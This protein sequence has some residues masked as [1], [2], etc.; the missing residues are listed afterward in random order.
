MLKNL[1][2]QFEKFFFP[3]DILS[4]V[5]IEEKRKR[6]FGF[7]AAF[8]AIPLLLGY[9]MT[10][11]FLGGE[12]KQIWPDLLAAGLLIAVVLILRKTQN[13]KIIYRIAMTGISGLFFYN[14][15][16]GL[17]KGGDILWLYTYPLIV[18]FLFGIVEGLFWIIAM[19][20]PVSVIVLFP[21]LTN[22]F[23]FPDVFKTRFIFSIIIVIFM[24]WLFESL[25]SHFFKQLTEQK[26]K[27]EAALEDVKTLSG[28]LPICSNCKKIR[29]DEGYW[30]QIEG[31]IQK[32]S[33]VTFSHGICSECSD[34]LYGKE[35]WYIKRKKKMG[36]I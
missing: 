16:L 5:P 32:H 4:Q 31:Y 36:K 25:R 23:V 2:K 30:N 3:E 21:G 11:L 18:F 8:I 33:D 26:L 17:Y 15:V 24:S 10:H 22:A 6:I 35:E 14:V 12:I 28:L 27:L 7:L 13:S 9:G 19:I 34:E 20:V 1:L 29:D